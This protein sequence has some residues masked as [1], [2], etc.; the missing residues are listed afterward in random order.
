MK[1]LDERANAVHWRLR[2]MK[3]LWS[4]EAEPE[5]PFLGPERPEGGSV[6]Q[7]DY[8]LAGSEVHG[9]TLNISGWVAFESGPTTRI[10]IWLDDRSLGRARLGI[11]RGDVAEM[12][13]L[14]HAP[15]AGFEMTADL[16][17]A[18]AAGAAGPA[19]LRMVATAADGRSF[20]AERVPIVLA[21]PPPD[22][23][24]SS[25]PPPV[26]PGTANG[27][28]GRRLLV[29]TH[30]LNLG[31]AQLYLMDLLR[32]LL[33]RGGFAPTVVSAMDGSLREELE[34]MGVPVHVTGVF[35]MEDLGAHLGRLEELT[36]WARPHEFELAFVNT[37]TALSFPGAEVASRLGIP[38]VW[39][40]HE[41][42]AP[43]IIWAPLDPEVRALGEEALSR[44]AFAVFEADATQRIYEPLLDGG[45]GRT[46]P[47]GLDLSPI[48]AKRESFDGA[49][50]RREAGIPADAELLVCIGTVEPRK[51]QIPLAQAFETIAERH[52]RAHLAFV[53]GKSTDPHS[54]ALEKCIANSPHAA[55]MRLIP[56]T[57]DVDPWYGMAD[58]L[59][60]ASDIESLPRTVLEAMAW[61]TPVLAT[62]VFGL[63]EL[64]EDGE[65]GWLCEPRDLE[66]LAAGIDRALSTSAEERRRIGRASRELVESRHALDTYAER[67]AELLEAASQNKE[68]GGQSNV[69]TS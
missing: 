36:A 3:R 43:A 22:P 45:R 49:A 11:P 64:I 21:P 32:G 58:V 52:P 41:S 31:G 62:S 13:D 29:A 33:E 63:P 35:P 50:A 34:A 16:S 23:E 19:T 39:A 53:G 55:Q 4:A 6:G 8:P 61:E 17:E 26:V 66:R 59:V 9:E 44:A 7:I 10:E 68:T 24:P 2:A 54:V 5:M 18:L 65:T 37:A 60:C 47:Y 69:A 14:P 20:E 38:A 56:I 46:I 42:F 28:Q 12:N 27:G 30:Q 25:P 48:A 1:R 67:I 15:V 40:I 57:P 51:A